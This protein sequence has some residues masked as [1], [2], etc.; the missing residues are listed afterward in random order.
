MQ[1]QLKFLSGN[2][3]RFIKLALIS[4]VFLFL[5]I[6]AISLLLPSTVHVSRAIDMDAPFDTIYSRI[7]DLNKWKSW[8][9]GLDSANISL[10]KETTGKGATLTM[11]NMKVQIVES[12]PEQVRTLWQSGAKSLEGDFNVFKQ[13][14]SSVITLQWHFT[15][16]VQWYPWEKFASIVSDKV[17]GPTMERSLD[18]LKKAV[19]R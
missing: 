18:N 4:V 12:K 5:L 10:S 6:T 19:E 14:G 3:M 17:L 7:N 9:A 15:Q 1:L 8:F 13:Q 2:N 16:H 11:N